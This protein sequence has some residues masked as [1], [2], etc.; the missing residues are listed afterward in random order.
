MTSATPSICVRVVLA[1]RASTDAARLLGEAGALARLLQAELA[2]L[3]VEESDLLRLAALPFTREIGPSGA[4]REIDLATTTRVLQREADQARELVARAASAL[5]LPWSFH[6]I[7]GTILQAALE[8][9]ASAD[10]VVV[11]PPRSAV[12]HAVGTRASVRPERGVAVLY[13]ATVAGERALATAL[14]LAQQQP[15]DVSLVVRDL[16]ERDDLQLRAARQRP[17]L[18]RPRAV[19]L[20]ELSRHPRRVLVVSRESLARLGL[21]LHQLLAL[22]QSPVVLVR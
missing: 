11:A 7:R 13:D 6:V 2:G 10:L 12:Q 17:D 1:T 22:A 8:A 16:A 18:A 3:F 5:D 14:R 21:D 15:E 19:T 4:V 20:S 9:A